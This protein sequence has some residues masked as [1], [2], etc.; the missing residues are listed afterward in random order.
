MTGGRVVILGPTGRNFGAGMSGGYAYVLDEDGHFAERCNTA[1]VRLKD[2]DAEDEET[3][4]RLIRRHFQYTRSARADEVLRKWESVAPKFI[5][6]SP[7]DY[8]RV[9]AER[10]SAGSGDG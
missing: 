3:I 9:L 10:L 2:I 1:I 6:V 4:L 7:I 5:K 8:E